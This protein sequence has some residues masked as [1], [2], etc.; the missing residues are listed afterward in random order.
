ME[1]IL[2]SSLYIIFVHNFNSPFPYQENNIYT[3]YKVI[4]DGVVP[5]ME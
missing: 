3:I 1:L 5:F 4:L 2:S